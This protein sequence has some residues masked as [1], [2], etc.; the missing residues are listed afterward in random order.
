[1]LQREMDSTVDYGIPLVKPKK[2]FLEKLF[3]RDVEAR[4]LE[5]VPVI[6]RKATADPVSDR[7][8]NETTEKTSKKGNWLKYLSRLEM[9]VQIISV[10]A[11][12]TLLGAAYAVTMTTG[13]RPSVSNSSIN[14]NI[15]PVANTSIIPEESISSPETIF[16]T[17]VQEESQESQQEAETVFQKVV[18]DGSTS[19]RDLETLIVSEETVE[20]PVTDTLESDL[21]LAINT[22]ITPP[23]TVGSTNHI[24]PKESLGD[25]TTSDVTAS[26]FTEEEQEKINKLKQQ[27][28]M[29]QEKSKKYDLSN[30]RLK[31]KLE[32][33]TV[34]NRA[35]SDQLRHLDN[36]SG[37]L[38]KQYKLDE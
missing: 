34:K 11:I 32:L 37:S 14:N 24:K 35:L 33:L 26:Q 5:N 7:I 6:T 38:K 30:V 31:G 36:L 17:V 13:E 21:L 23:I 25:I 29:V 8:F 9:P 22:S 18:F 15:V 16:S 4:L 20:Q 27:I 19:E 3:K 12:G 28:V 1:M 10:V 2:G